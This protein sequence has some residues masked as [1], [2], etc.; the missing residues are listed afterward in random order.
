M[1]ADI[2][3][4][5]QQFVAMQE[6]LSHMQR[7]LQHLHEVLINQQRQLDLLMSHH[8]RTEELLQRALQGDNFPSAAEDRPPHY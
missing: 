2:D 8:R 6:V 7:D 4:L 5:T 3:R 1:S